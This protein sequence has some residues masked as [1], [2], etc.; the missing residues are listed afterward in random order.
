MRTDID[1]A[2]GAAAFFFDFGE[3]GAFVPVGF[4][5]VVIGDRIEA[6]GLCGSAGDDGI[7]YAHDRRGVHAAAKLC[8]DGAVGAEPAPDGFS[9]D[10]AEV[11]PARRTSGSRIVLQV[12]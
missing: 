2:T 7:C 3:I 5:V 1:V 12:I 9:K 11:L 8:K 10:S 4:G 6:R